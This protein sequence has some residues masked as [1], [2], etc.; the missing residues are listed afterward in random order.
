MHILIAALIS[1]TAHAD[2]PKLADAAGFQTAP[3]PATTPAADPGTPAMPE[4]RPF[5]H[6]FSFRVRGMTVPDSLLDIWY[7][8]EDD[9]GWALTGQKRPQAAGYALGFEYCIKGPTANG[10]FYFDYADSTMKAGYWDD[11]ENPADHLD[12]SY[13][14]PDKN[15]GLVALGADFGYEVHFVRT[16]DTHG[17]FGLSFIP[18]AGLGVVIVTGHLQ[19]WTPTVDGPA[20]VLY[21]QGEPAHDTVRVPGVLPMLD[22]NMALRFNFGDRVVMK[23]ETGLHDVIYYGGTLGI[24][25]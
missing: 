4:E 3:P 17:A 8:N 9:D 6:E 21:Q 16:S 19:E 18:G 10:I 24:M 14:V 12:G 2:A 5:H 13:I 25:F 1:T 22:I 15:F 11:V 23:F 20:Y 7:F